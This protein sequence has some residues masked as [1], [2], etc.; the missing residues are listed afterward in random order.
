MIEKV[1]LPIAAQEG[2]NFDVD[3]AH[4]VI[5]ATAKAHAGEELSDD[6]F[7]MVAGGKVTAND[8]GTALAAACQAVDEI[9]KTWRDSYYDDDD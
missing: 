2:F 8:V 5:S 1:I 4:S 6:E 3:H 9:R 7:E